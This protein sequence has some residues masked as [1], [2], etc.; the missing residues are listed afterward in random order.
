MNPELEALLRTTL[1]DVLGIPA[2][3][4]DDDTSTDTVESWDSLAH[5][6]LIIAL[7]ETFAITVP[8]DEAVDLTSYPL[9]RLTVGEQLAAAG[10]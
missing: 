1:A 4:I 7:E 9:L 5:M 8:D 6:N 2:E 3:T 10:T